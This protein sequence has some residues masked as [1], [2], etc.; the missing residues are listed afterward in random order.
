MDRRLVGRLSWCSRL[1]GMRRSH[2]SERSACTCVRV[3]E[4][5]SRTKPGF[6]DCSGTEA[7]AKSV[8]PS[9]G[10]A[11]SMQAQRCFSTRQ[12]K[13]H[14]LSPPRAERVPT[15]HP[16][17]D[18]SP[19][20]DRNRAPLDEE[21][22][23]IHEGSGGKSGPWLA[24]DGKR[25]SRDPDAELAASA[26][27]TRMQAGTGRSRVGGGEP[28]THVPAVQSVPLPEPSGQGRDRDVN[29]VTNLLAPWFPPPERQRG[30]LDRAS[31]Q[32]RVR[33]RPDSALSHGSLFGW[34]VRELAVPVPS[35]HEADR[36]RALRF[37]D[38]TA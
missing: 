11:H 12:E 23:S 8:A 16:G 21:D 24:A 18:A 4:S 3:G 1:R 31:L 35:I 15:H 17:S 37:Q 5:A 7:A 26:V 34:I 38:S 13:A 22:D 19:P 29:A 14:D 9:Q 20:A 2:R 32:S 10:I 25:Q 6:L 28:A 33:E 30:P 27:A 36:G